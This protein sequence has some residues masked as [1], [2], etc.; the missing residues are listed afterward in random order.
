MLRLWSI[1]YYPF[2]FIPNA[3]FFKNVMKACCHRIIP[4]AFL[5]KHLFSDFFF[6]FLAL[7]MRHHIILKGTNLWFF[8][9][10]SKGLHGCCSPYFLQWAICICT[11]CQMS[12]LVT[13]LR[14]GHYPSLLYFLHNA[15]YDILSSSQDESSFYIF[16][17]DE[18]Q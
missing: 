18:N 6:L 1:E 15:I 4:H 13:V 14:N 9:L 7:W 16:I 10:Y 11:K 12:S 2:L 3:Y 17:E 5:W 8:M